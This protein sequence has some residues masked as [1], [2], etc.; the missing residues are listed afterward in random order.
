MTT[1]KNTRLELTGQSLTEQID[2]WTGC[3]HVLWVLNGGETEE[4]NGESCDCEYIQ[5]NWNCKR[6]ILEEKLQG[7]LD[8]R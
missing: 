4:W 1:T 3:C 6:C 5:G 2:Y 8:A 7:D